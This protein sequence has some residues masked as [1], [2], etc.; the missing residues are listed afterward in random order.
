MGQL[1]SARRFFRSEPLAPSFFRQRS[2]L[3]FIYDF[4]P[5]TTVPCCATFILQAVY[6][7]QSKLSLAY[8]YRVTGSNKV[9]Y[10]HCITC[11]AL[12]VK[13]QTKG[14]AAAQEGYQVSPS[15]L[16]GLCP[17][18]HYR[19]PVDK[20]SRSRLRDSPQPRLS[21]LHLLASTHSL[22]SHPSD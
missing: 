8:Q 5:V 18:T 17:S 9:C 16:S 3:C 11:A 12:L 15:S 21:F 14:L 7:V 2:S 10:V 4:R 19:L 1:G 20:L 22:K 13:H 6:K